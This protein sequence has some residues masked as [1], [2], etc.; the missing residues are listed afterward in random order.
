MPN[1]KTG[2]VGENITDMI[3]L[4]KS[5]KVDYKNDKTANVHVPV[6]KVNKEFT[7]EKIIENI[8]AFFE[9][10]DKAKPEGVKK[11]LVLRAFVSTSASPS[12]RIK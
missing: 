11:T 9:S 7:V 12:I 6:G 4:I 3:K 2:T 1:P 8:N 10:L 5:G